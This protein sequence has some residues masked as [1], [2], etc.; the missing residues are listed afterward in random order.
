MSNKPSKGFI[1][2]EFEETMAIFTF[3]IDEELI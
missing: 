1:V 3:E 2:G